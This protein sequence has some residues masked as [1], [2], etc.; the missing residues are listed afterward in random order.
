MGLVWVGMGDEWKSTLLEA[1]DGWG[2]E[3]GNGG[4]G[5]DVTFAMLTNIIIFN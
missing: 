4:P 1:G 2:G 3:I 5:R